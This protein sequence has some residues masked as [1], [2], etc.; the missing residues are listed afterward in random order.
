VVTELDQEI[1]AI[2]KLPDVKAQ[3]VPACM[4]IGSGVVVLKARLGL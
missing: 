2:I 3:G 4:R 1:N